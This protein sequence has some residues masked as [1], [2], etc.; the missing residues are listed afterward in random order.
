[1]KSFTNADLTKEEI[2]ECFDYV[3]HTLFETIDTLHRQFEDTGLYN[4]FRMKT[5][6]GIYEESISIHFLGNEIW[7]SESDD[8]RYVEVGNLLGN[9]KECLAKYLIKKITDIL[10]L[11]LV[12]HKNITEE[13]N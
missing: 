13:D 10:G 8:R 4:I 11:L 2:T 1:M 6:K 5:H 7:N 9:D 12:L 3:T